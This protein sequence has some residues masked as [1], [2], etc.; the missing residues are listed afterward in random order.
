[1]TSQKLSS[2]VQHYMPNIYQQVS[3]KRLLH[4]EQS[5]NQ[6]AHILINGHGYI[7]PYH[8]SRSL[9]FAIGGQILP[10]EYQKTW[11]LE[12]ASPL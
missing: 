6:I 8:R 10:E 7:P 4:T 5:L 3:S 9:G 12:A 2:Q 11:L 1:M